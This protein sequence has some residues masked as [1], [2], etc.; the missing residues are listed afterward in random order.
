MGSRYFRR[1]GVIAAVVA[2]VVM[3]VPVSALADNPPVAAPQTGNLVIHKYAMPDVSKAGEPNNGKELTTEP[4]GATAL[5]GITFD[6]YAVVITVGNYPADGPWTLTDNEDPTKGFTDSKGI[7]FDVEATKRASIETGTDGG[8]YTTAKNDQT[9]IAEVD[10]LAAGIYLVVEEKSDL[11]DS[12]SAPFVVAVPMA[13]PDYDA[14]NPSSAAWLDTVH[15]YPKNEQLSIDKT[16]SQSAV[17]VGE[18][19]SWDVVTA[20]PSDLK[21]AKSFALSDVLDSALDFVSVTDDAMAAV[22]VAGL[23]A[24][25]PITLQQ[26]VDYMVSPT[27]A[28]VGPVTVTITFNLSNP[29]TIAK[30]ATARYARFTINTTANKGILAKAH[31][32]I[33]NH[34]TIDFVNSFDQEKHI[35][36]DPKDVHTATLDIFKED[37]ADKAPL[38]GASFAVALNKADADGGNYLHYD[39]STDTIIFPGASNYASF[40][41]WTQTTDS[42][43]HAGF[44]G[45]FDTTNQSGETT[46]YA[47]YW[48]IETAAPKGYNPLIAPIQ[49]TFDGTENFDNSYTYTVTVDNHSGFTLPKTGAT[50][51]IVF[52]I[53][54][55]VLVS[56]AVIIAVNRRKRAIA[57]ATIK[58]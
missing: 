23:K 43:G 6:V 39:A 50:G 48:L 17:E 16:P 15:A 56:G 57:T 9:G 4:A 12:P 27:T 10:G 37:G 7:H 5:N 13:N 33:E 18:P 40:P 30:L 26:G 46:A 8:A 14:A 20:L 53:I 55:V 24:A 35:D 32:S 21:D 38:S 11:V 44:H 31:Q 22:T 49:V 58:S 19:F 54:G 41:V 2:L 29:D 28:T 1:I 51:I 25:T 47:S 42:S 34:A 52:S 36:S 45:L 3:L